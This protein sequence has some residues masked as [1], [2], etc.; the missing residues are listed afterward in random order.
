[1]SRLQLGAVIV[2]C[3]WLLL[4]LS[5]VLF[6]SQANHIDLGSMFASPA[7]N[8]YGLFGYD[9][10]GRSILL[11]IITG[12]QV[13]LLVAVSVTL[14]TSV[15]G[16]LIGLL[17]GWFGGIVDIILVRIMDIFLAFPGILL[18]IALAGLLGPGIANVIIA[19]A[20]TGWVGFARL[21][22]AQV[23]SLRHREHVLAA[24]SLGTMT[25]FILLRH[26]LP[27]MLAP[28]LVEATFAIAG[29][30][31]AEAGLSFLGLGVQAPQASWGGMLRDAVRYLL[32]AP[33]MTIAP[34]LTIMLV[35]L[36]VNMLGDSLRDRLD[37][38]LRE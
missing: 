9:D 21:G 16:T 30:V 34:A 8:I 32:V 7:V 4:A 3:C 37:I 27:L 38:R 31:I 20:V 26:I 33:H 22:R 28:L 19:L 13:S 10:L 6:A 23:L 2:L 11:R 17:S 36:S 12:A 15:T 5:G 18:A 29:A 24:Q 14:L 35:V 1:M 25:P